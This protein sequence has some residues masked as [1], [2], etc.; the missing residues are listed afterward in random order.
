MQL[1]SFASK[2]STQVIDYCVKNRHKKQ[3]KS[4]NYIIEIHMLI[5]V[6]SEQN[7]NIKELSR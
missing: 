5:S 3:E 6:H 2:S 1:L 4:I 7:Y